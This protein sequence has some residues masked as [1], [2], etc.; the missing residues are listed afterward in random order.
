MIIARCALTQEIPMT[1]KNNAV[2]L[3]HNQVALDPDPVIASTRSAETMDFELG[4]MYRDVTRKLQLDSSTTVLELGCGIGLLATYIAPR[5]ASVTGVDFADKAVERFNARGISNCRGIVG[6]AMTF[7]SQASFDRVL[8]YATFHYVKSDDEAKALIDSCIR[9]CKR[10]GRI[11]VGSIPLE[12]LNLDVEKYFKNKWGWLFKGSADIGRNWPW[13]FRALCYRLAKKFFRARSKRQ[14]LLVPEGF[15]GFISLNR[16]QIEGWLR[17]KNVSYQWLRPS[18]GIPQFLS[19]A[20]LLIF[21]N[22]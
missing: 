16:R 7:R 12:E 13:R 21:P 8:M 2:R 9:N 14:P 4:L 6:D 1:D 5:C 11:L 22:I 19:R 10:G 17:E 18:I 3:V 15:S 20:D